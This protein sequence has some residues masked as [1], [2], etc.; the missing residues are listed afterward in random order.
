[1]QTRLVI[2]KAFDKHHNLL[3]IL[4]EVGGRLI[5]FGPHPI[6]AGERNRSANEWTGIG[7]ATV[8]TLAEWKQWSYH[9][10]HRFERVTLL[11]DTR[12]FSAK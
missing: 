5:P 11:G 10:A 8:K 4:V 7:F 6:T 2:H 1:M 12:S 9:K 3:R